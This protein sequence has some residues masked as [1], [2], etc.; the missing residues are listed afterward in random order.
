MARIGLN[1]DGDVVD[2]VV[3]DAVVVNALVV[4]VDDADI[5][6]THLSQRLGSRTAPQFC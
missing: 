4:A 3:V 1:D 6:L 5:S 2:I